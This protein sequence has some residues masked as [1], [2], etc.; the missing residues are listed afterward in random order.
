MGDRKR[1]DDEDFV[2]YK[3]EPGMPDVLRDVT[4][5]YY[6]L[7][8][9]AR[10]GSSWMSLHRFLQASEEPLDLAKK[11]LLMELRRNARPYEATRLLKLIIAQQRIQQLRSDRKLLDS[12]LATKRS[13][14]ENRTPN[15][16]EP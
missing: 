8:S 3:W 13:I 4:V 6:E 7:R 15:H 12:Y 11:F 9:F 16:I 14:W 2:V 10:A 5:Y 1:Y